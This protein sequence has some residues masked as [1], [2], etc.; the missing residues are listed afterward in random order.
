MKMF[1]NMI[2]AMGLAAAMLFQPSAP[3]SAKIQRDNLPSSIET[4]LQGQNHIQGVAFDGKYFYVSFTTR[5]M[6]YDIDGRVVGSVEGLTGHLGCLTRKGS[7]VFGSLEYKDDEIGKGIR[8]RLGISGDDDRTGFYIAIFDTRKITRVGMDAEKDGIMKAVWLKEPLDDYSAKAGGHDH[9]Y[10]CSG[11]DGVTFGPS[12]GEGGKAEY[13]Y[14]AYGIYGDTTRCD[15]DYQVIL[16]Y[17]V[18]DWWKR[19]AMPLSQAN[20]HKS[21][22]KAP[23]AKYFLLTGNTTYG[24]QNLAYDKTSGNFYAAVYKGKKEKWPNYS[25][26]MIDGA[27]APVLSHLEGVG[28]KGL[29]LSLAE[30][31]LSSEGIRGWNFKWGS[32]GLCPVGGGYF[33]LSENRK[34]KATGEQASTI[35]L[36][37]WTCD[38]ETPFVPAN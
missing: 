3:A 28:E 4:G 22:P 31:G 25:L 12:F 13:L 6:K 17:D 35:R 10:A 27:K 37:R 18:K 8:R 29:T 24:I 11:I 32:T 2:M 5:L 23:L 1:R 19:L 36:Y 33:Y 21:G 15:N 26:F 38:L 34:D 9:R 16:K 7:F 20:L 30:A 14:V